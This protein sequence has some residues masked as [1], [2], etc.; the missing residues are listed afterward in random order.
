MVRGQNVAVQWDNEKTVY[1]G[2][3]TEVEE[4]EEV[5][6]GTFLEKAGRFYRERSKV[7]KEPF[8][9]DQILPLYPVLKPAPTTRRN[10]WVV[11]NIDEILEIAK[12]KKI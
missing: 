3:V 8:H 6:Y 4:A 11:E 7:E 9:Y 2:F 5:A 1:I 10:A 12:Q